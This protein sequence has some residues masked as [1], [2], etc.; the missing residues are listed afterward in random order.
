MIRKNFHESGALF[1]QELK[2]STEKCRGNF[3]G[4]IIQI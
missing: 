4:W 3:S 1:L 2:V